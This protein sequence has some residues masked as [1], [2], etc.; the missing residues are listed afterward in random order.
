MRARGKRRQHSGQAGTVAI[1]EPDA[2][3]PR[4]QERIDAQAARA[5]LGR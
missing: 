2:A 3:A 5:E 1:G 4:A